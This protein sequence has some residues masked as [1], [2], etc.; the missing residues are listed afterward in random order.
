MKDKS[1]QNFSISNSS[2]N[3]RITGTLNIYNIHQ[4]K[5]HLSGFLKKGTT[6]DF[7]DL[8]SLDT[9]AAIMLRSFA[10]KY[11][12]SFE[13]VKKE[14]LSLFQLI[15]DVPLETLPEDHKT[16][17]LLKGIAY[18]GRSAVKIKDSTYEIIS[19]F[20]HT[21]VALFSALLR[22]R[23]LRVG[24]IVHHIE[25]IFIKAIP[26]VS[27]IAFLISIVL[28]YQGIAQLR[29]LG[30][31]RFTVNLVAISVLREMGVLLTAIMVAGRSGSAFTAE[32]GVM[33]IREEVDALKTMGINSFEI[34][35]IPRL[36]AIIISLPL[37]TFIAD[38]MG[39]AGGAVLSSAL[40]GISLPEYIDRIHDVV[41]FNTFMVGMIK[42]PVFAFA[43]AV[44]GCLHGMKVTGS[45]ESV[46]EE[47]TRSVVKS[48]F[49]V[50]LLDAVF[51]IIFEQIGL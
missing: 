41:K 12:V 51:S 13:N 15:K 3:I 28:A 18:V 27:L 47:T 24:S 25:E 11:N 1:S 44:V 31:Q 50:L 34:L 38:I 9:A 2:G 40:I 33:K 6:I 43:I 7:A 42:A 32:I 19:F 10:E 20:G 8:I 17:A 29:P 5:K 48:I 26:I 49:I 22:P 37:L 39:L 30:A 45:S 21:C 46:G 16:P 36:I 14:H 23:K 4:A 35:V